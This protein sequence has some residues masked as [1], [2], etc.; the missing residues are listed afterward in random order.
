ML[1]HNGLKLFFNSI[2]ANIPLD[3]EIDIKDLKE[4]CELRNYLT[5]IFGSYVTNIFMYMFL[6][7]RKTKGKDRIIE[8]MI[9]AK[10][11]SDQ[12][13]NKNEII[14]AATWQHL[15]HNYIHCSIK[16]RRFKLVMKSCDCNFHSFLIYFR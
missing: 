7:H 16:E 11:N 14:N 15:I 2:E 13:Q 4:N 1:T 3:K 5:F 6:D 9:T 12:N 8:A 10:R